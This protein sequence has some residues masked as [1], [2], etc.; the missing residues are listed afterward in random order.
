[1]KSIQKYKDID[2]WNETPVL[3]KEVFEK[4][5]D[6]IEEAGELDKRADYNKVV[7]NKYAEGAIK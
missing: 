6:V 5:Q 4:L 7:N 1:M 3:T 2:A